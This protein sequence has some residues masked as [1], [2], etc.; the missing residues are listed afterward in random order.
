MR[1]RWTPSSIPAWARRTR[2][3]G[4]ACR[5]WSSMAARRADDGAWRPWRRRNQRR[6]FLARAG[7][8]AASAASA[9]R[10]SDGFGARAAI[11][12][13]FG[14]QSRERIR[15]L[16]GIRPDA[17]RL[18][19]ASPDSRGTPPREAAQLRDA[20]SFACDRCRRWIH[21]RRRRGDGPTH[22]PRSR[23][24]A[25]RGTDGAAT[26]RPATR[27]ARASRRAPAGR[28]RATIAAARSRPD[29]RHGAPAQCR[30]HR[31]CERCIACR[32][33]GGLEALAAARAT[34]TR[35]TAKG[36]PRVEHAS[37]QNAAHASALGER[38]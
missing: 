4:P 12:R 3:S 2:A 8:E 11:D 21:R 37:A 10:S 19:R 6:R 34:V 27:A 18:L 16:R 29:R 7:A 24:W 15:K 30:A 1:P 5:S 36:T 38:P 28:R 9:A 35:R 17:R 20:G 14:I 33:R 23:S 13:T 25:A 22:R 31:R 32:A 26:A